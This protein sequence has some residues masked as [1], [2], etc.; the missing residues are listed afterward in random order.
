MLGDKLPNSDIW[1]EEGSRSLHVQAGGATERT[2][3]LMEI[4]FNGPESMRR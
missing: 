1:Y 3:E 2:T 4:N